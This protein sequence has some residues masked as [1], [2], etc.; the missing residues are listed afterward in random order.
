MS[1][2]RTFAPSLRRRQRRGP[3]A[4]AEVQD[5]EP[6]GDPERLHERL[7]ALAHALRDA[8]EVAL[9]PERLVRI[10]GRC[11]F[12]LSSPRA[13]RLILSARGCA[14]KC[15]SRVGR[16]GRLEVVGLERVRVWRSSPRGRV[17]MLAG[18]DWIVGRGERWVVVGP[19]GAGED[20]ADPGRL[21]ADAAERRRRA[22][23]RRAARALPARGAAPPD[24]R[25]RPA[26]LAAL[27][28][29]PDRARRRA[30]RRRRDGAERRGRGRAA[31]RASCSRSLASPRSPGGRSSSCSEGE[32]ARVLLAR[33]LAADAELLLL[34]EPTAG[35]DLPAADCSSTRW[36]RLRA[37]PELT[38]ITVTHE[39]DALPP[40]TTHVLM[41]RAGSVVAAGPREET[42][43][44]QRRRLLRPA[45]RRG[46]AA[47]PLAPDE[48]RRPTRRGRRP[49]ASP[50]T[51]TGGRRG[52][53]AA[54]WRSPYSKSVGS[55]RIRAPCARACSQW[56]RASSTRTI[57]ECVTSPAPRRP[58][59]V[60]DVADD[61]A[62]PSPTL[63]CER[64]ASPIRRRSA[65][66]NAVGQPRDAARTSG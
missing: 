8:R 35:L 5:L 21:G 39:L 56:A 30:D 60:A 43:T 24:R 17:D 13:E 65:N 46:A 51:S 38:T 47:R 16:L 53:S 48:R 54:Y 42:L 58:A 27:L 32:H 22:R 2:P 11:P 49:R 29:R 36:P 10:H 7:A 66:P 3:V 40:E 45:A 33:A 52:P 18:V 25:R 12:R 20:D 50:R 37:R 19:N 1:T 6:V 41:L 14:A 9:L 61:H 57:T 64:W 44:A 62:P 15:D 63:S 4:A 34:D 59:L 31:A 55:I 26:A 28:P 23:P